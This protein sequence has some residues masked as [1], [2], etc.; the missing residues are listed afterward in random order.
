MKLVR[1]DVFHPRIVLAGCRALPEGDGDDAGLVEALRARG[2]DF[3]ESRGLHTEA[4]GA[5][6]APAL[7]GLMFELVHDPRS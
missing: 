5:L 2:V 1:P 7:G 6:T 3:V 4:R